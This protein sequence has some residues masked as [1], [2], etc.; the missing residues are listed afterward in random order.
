MAVGE[1]LVDADAL[2]DG[3]VFLVGVGFGDFGGTGLVSR[4][5]GVVGCTATTLGVGFGVGLAAGLGGRE[6]G[7]LG[8]FGCCVVVL[9]TSPLA[10]PATWPLR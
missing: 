6:A 5:D 3:D 8:E 2:A 10:W 4:L 7:T 1:V 9:P